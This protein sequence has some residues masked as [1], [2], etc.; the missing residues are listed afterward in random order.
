MRPGTGQVWAGDGDVLEVE[1]FDGAYAVVFS[2]Q[3]QCQ[4][5]VNGSHFGRLFHL[6]YGPEASL[7]W[8]QIWV[9]PSAEVA[10][11][12][13]WIGEI[14]AALLRG[15]KGFVIQQEAAD[16]LE[17]FARDARGF[18]VKVFGEQ[19]VCDEVVRALASFSPPGVAVAEAHHDG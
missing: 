11:E 4:Q 19:V 14:D 1:S 7:Q 15:G 2:R 3:A 9:E 10:D 17:R 16:A 5:L 8:H 18:E 12:Q 13:A 6:V